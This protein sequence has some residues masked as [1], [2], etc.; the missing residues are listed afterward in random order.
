MH[1]VGERLRGFLDKGGLVICGL[2]CAA[3][4][5]ISY[6]LA[7][8]PREPSQSAAVYEDG[9]RETAS[10][11]V[12]VRL[13]YTKTEAPPHFETPLRGEISRD[14]S[15]NMVFF[16]AIGVYRAHMAVDI[17]AAAGSA[18][19]AVTDGRAIDAGFRDDIGFY[20]LIKHS[21]GFQALYA[22]LASL[23]SVIA[24]DPVRTGDVIGLA[25][26]SAL[27]EKDDG[28]HLHFAVYENGLPLDP[29]T[30]SFWEN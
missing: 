5:I 17:A 24:G 12:T 29:R 23:P 2:L 16:E 21:G 15:E 30:L 14:Y 25:G 22:S 4:I 27:L 7:Q 3:A 20:A 26:A 1:K 19:Y 6:A 11:I 9:A 13:L 18:V 8:T 10:P 28:A